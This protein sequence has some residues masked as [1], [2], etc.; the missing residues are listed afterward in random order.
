MNN[1]KTVLLICLLACSLSAIAQENIEPGYIIK[2]DGFRQE[3]MLAVEDNISTPQKFRFKQPDGK[4]VN[5]GIDDNIQEIG[6]ND[7]AFKKFVVQIDKSTENLDRLDEEK[8][9]NFVQDVLFLEYVLSGSVSL[10]QYRRK[11]LIKFFYQQANEDIQQLKYKKHLLVTKDQY[12]R[13]YAKGKVVENTAYKY[14][15]FEAFESCSNINSSYIADLNHSKKDLVKFFRTVNECFG[16]EAVK[17]LA[18]KTHNRFRIYPV[19]KMSMEDFRYEIGTDIIT[20]DN[21]IGYGAGLRIHFLPINNNKHLSLF[22]EGY[23][24][25]QRAAS[26]SED[27]IELMMRVI[28]IPFGLQYDFFLSDKMALF[29]NGGY[30]LMLD[31]NK[32]RVTDTNISRY[33]PIS[34]RD[35]AFASLGFTFYNIVVAELRYNS[36]AKVFDIFPDSNTSYQPLI[37][38]VGIDVLPLLHK[39]K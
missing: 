13:S 14:Q 9:F 22:T 23:Y 12:G 26:T 10:Y 35:N 37:L 8:T 4:W 28:N 3:V 36:P 11:G 24:T 27:G 7:K 33:L 25:H 6:T 20:F 30:N 21:N 38:T 17:E 16:D 29:L 31:L 39:K 5:I 2:E 1:K 18:Q 19:F 34:T 32:S 15:L